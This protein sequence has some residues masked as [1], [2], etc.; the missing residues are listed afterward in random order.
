MLLHTAFELAG[1][2]AG[3]ALYASLRRREGDPLDDRTRLVVI[4]GAAIGASLGARLLWWLGEPGLGIAHLFEGKTVVGGLLGGLLAVELT[5]KLTGIT[6]RTGDLFVYPLI[7]AIGIGRVGCFLSGPA[8][9]THGLPTNLPWAIAIGDGVPRHPVAL[10]EIAFLLAIVVPLR[11]TRL[12]GDRFALFLLAYLTFRFC[13]DFLK[14]YPLPVYGIT[15][16]QW[17][18][19]AGVAYYAVRFGTRPRMVVQ[20]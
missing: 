2:A 19:L 12:P 11:H 4:V 7:T 17:A 6:T 1:S 9:Q 14:P 3:L 10:Y 18:C 8:D 20:Q 5:K 16:I 15:A 13:A